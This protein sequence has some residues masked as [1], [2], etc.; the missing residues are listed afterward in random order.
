MSAAPTLRTGNMNALG[1]E[2]ERMAANASYDV[3]IR[4][5]LDVDGSG[6]GSY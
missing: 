1:R 4:N 6:L 2:G 5:G 3:V